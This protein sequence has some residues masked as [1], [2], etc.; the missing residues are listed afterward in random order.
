MNNGKQTHQQTPDMAQRRQQM[1]E[2]DQVIAQ[3][4]AQ[5]ERC[6]QQAGQ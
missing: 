5:I 3:R 1:A 2:Q 6:R 4:L